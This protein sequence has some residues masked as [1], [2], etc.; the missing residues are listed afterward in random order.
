MDKPGSEILKRRKALGLT[1]KELGVKC[2]VS[3]VTIGH[4][5]NNRNQ[6]NAV[7]LFRLCA[8]LACAPSDIVE[9]D[10]FTGDEILDAEANIV[11]EQYKSS[12]EETRSLI[13]RAFG[14][15][16]LSSSGDS[17]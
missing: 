11:R 6:F 10:H 8:A 2:G 4:W 15:K 13:L 17:D 3:A 14:V 7:N 16:P 9:D 12:S 1:Q 5:E